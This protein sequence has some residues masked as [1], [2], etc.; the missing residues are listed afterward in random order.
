MEYVYKTR[1]Q[2]G[3]TDMTG[4][5]YF[6]AMQR[7]ALEAFENFLLESD[8]Q[9]GEVFLPIR[10]VEA[11][12]TGVLKLWDEVTVRL[13]CTKVGES[14]IVME[15]EIENAGRVQ[16]VHVCVDQSGKKC[17]LS[18]TFKSLLK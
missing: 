6:A 16:I 18:E 8:F 15:S 3:D 1:V 12:Y 13:R 2:M 7:F 9:L 11:D 14:S 10:H 17:P 5:L 4:S